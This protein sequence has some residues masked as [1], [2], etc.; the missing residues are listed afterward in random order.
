MNFHILDTYAIYQ[1]LLATEDAATRESI[2]RQELIAPFQ[3]VIDLFGGGDSL[4]AFRN[5]G[6]WPDQY[7]GDAGRSM[8]A[9]ID[10]LAAHQ[11]WD[12]AA[13]ALH[14]GRDAFAK[15]ADRIPTETVVFGLMLGELMPQAGGYTGFGSI[16]GWVMTIYGEANDDNL[17]K[18]EAVTVHELHHNIAA[19]SG[20]VL[21]NWATTSVG[22]YM[23]AEG[24]AESFAAELY[25]E[26][27]IGPW[28][29]DFDD[30][31]LD[32]VRGIFRDALHLTGS[33]LIRSYIFGTRISAQFGL[34]TDIDLP[35]YAGYA[36]GYKVVQAY[37]KRTGKTVADATFTPVSEVIAE[38]GFFDA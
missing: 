17:K 8:A 31:Q 25:G 9:L 14:K 2:F 19:A 38:S 34:P 15:Y 23:L 30:S 28:V 11:A 36:L 16:P 26:D 13:Q 21:S 20:S 32:R 4:T 12:R 10:T 37:L 5:W 27:K 24:L 1:R 35:D 7:T 6:M 18:V 22:E 29:T 3:G 33:A